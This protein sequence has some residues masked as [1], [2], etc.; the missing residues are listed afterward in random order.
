MCNVRVRVSEDA[1]GTNE[2]VKCSLSLSLSLVR[3]RSYHYIINLD[4]ILTVPESFHSQTGPAHIIFSAAAITCFLIHPFAECKIPLG[5]NNQ[6]EISTWAPHTVHTVFHPSPIAHTYTHTLTNHHYSKVHL[7]CL[8][9]KYRF[10][11]KTSGFQTFIEIGIDSL[12]NELEYPIENGWKW[13]RWPSWMDIWTTTRASLTANSN[14]NEWATHKKN[15][16][17][18]RN[19]AKETSLSECSR[20]NQTE[21]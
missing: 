4:I 11:A 3:P 18:E 19:K 17:R 14:E 6:N 9:D 7:R 21:L 16:R 1:I 20:L 13:R 12:A 2:R 15:K 8:N 10:E 5:T